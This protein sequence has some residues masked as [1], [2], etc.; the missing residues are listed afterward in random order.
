MTRCLVIVTHGS[1]ETEAVA[2]IDLLRRAKMD[3]VVAGLTGADPVQCSR[4]VVLVPDVA[5]AEASG[6]FD[7]MILPGGMG[8][9]EAFAA[10]DAIKSQLTTYA[11]AGKTVG[12]ICA[13]PMAL[14]KHGVFSDYRM[15]SHPVVKELVNAH[16]TWEKMPV[17]KDRNLITSQGP[18]TALHFALALIE[19]L[20]GAD[21]AAEVRAPLMMP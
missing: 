21:T 11:A 13:A 10:S 17:V 9:A 3:V 2:T 5:L 16:G 19:H 14:C 8:G 20:E 6:D 15:T 18:G 12:A 7:A 4:A 1:E